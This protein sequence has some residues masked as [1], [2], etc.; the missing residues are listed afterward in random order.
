M[1]LHQLRQHVILRAQ[2]VLEMRD[3]ALRLEVRTL[4]RAI[5][6][7]QRGGAILKQLLEPAV[8]DGGLELGLLADRGY[9]DLVDQVAPQERH[10][11][12]S[13]EVLPSAFHVGVLRAQ[14]YGWDTPVPAEA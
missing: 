2:P 7:L 9:R 1:V 12:C 5:G 14:F 4:R 8:E 3:A 10:L 6:T 13:R 11:L